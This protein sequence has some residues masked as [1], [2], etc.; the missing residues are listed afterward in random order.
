MRRERVDGELGEMTKRRVA[1]TE[2]RLDYMNSPTFEKAN[3]FFLDGLLLV[4]IKSKEELLRLEGL[5]ALSTS[6]PG[7]AYVE[8]HVS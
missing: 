3:F 6:A 2:D 5:L 8:F 4:A 1:K 7:I